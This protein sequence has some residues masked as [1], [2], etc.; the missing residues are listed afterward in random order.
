VK[1]SKSMAWLFVLKST[2]HKLYLLVCGIQ[3]KAN[4]KQTAKHNTDV[5]CSWNG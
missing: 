1:R 4:M 3:G 5:A 2:S